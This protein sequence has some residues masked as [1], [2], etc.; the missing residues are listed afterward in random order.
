VPHPRGRPPPGRPTGNEG[1]V[2]RQDTPPAEAWDHG[3]GCGWGWDVLQ[4]LAKLKATSWA[5]EAV[6][7]VR[8]TNPLHPGDDLRAVLARKVAR[9]SRPPRGMVAADDFSRRAGSGR[10]VT[11]N[12]QK[13]VEFFYF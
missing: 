10:A 7:A 2:A 12:I 4:P 5:D 8:A 6:M 1:Q 13:R 9:R 11:P 3:P